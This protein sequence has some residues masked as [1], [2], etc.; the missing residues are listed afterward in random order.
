MFS[1]IVGNLIWACG[2]GLLFAR[3]LDGYWDSG[4]S[5]ILSNFFLYIQKEDKIISCKHIFISYSNFGDV[6]RKQT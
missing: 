5:V 3:C 2:I 6:Q 1:Y 4:I